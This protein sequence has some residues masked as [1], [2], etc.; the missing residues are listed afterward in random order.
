MSIKKPMRAA[1][2]TTDA[3]YDYLGATFPSLTSVKIDGIRAL[4]HPLHGPVSRT[5]KSIPNEHILNGMSVLPDYLDGELITVNDDGTLRGYNDLQGDI[6]RR[7]GRPNFQFLIFDCFENPDAPF[8]ERFAQAQEIVRGYGGAL[9][10]VDHTPVATLIEMQDQLT[11]AIAAGYEGLMVRHPD[12]LYK[13]GTS[14]VRQGWLVKLKEMDD[15][16]GTV[17][18][19]NERMHNANDATKDVQGKTKRSTNKD[20]LVPMGT[21]GA[22]VLDTQWGELPV[23]SGFTDDLRQYIWDNQEQ[24]LGKQAT[25]RYQAYGAKDKPR[26]P[27][28]KGFRGD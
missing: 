27:S 15:D 14:T 13:E 8:S 22:L 23:G 21:L 19:F 28:F 20:G 6:M 16:E 4:T 26:F 12:G 7:S 11:A 1:R 25:F 24:F 2:L 17:I 3:D 9:R 5:F 18:G 10:I